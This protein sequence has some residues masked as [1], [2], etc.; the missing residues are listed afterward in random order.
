MRT[1]QLARLTMLR[2]PQRRPA[3]A[4][5]ASAS[6]LIDRDASAIKLEVGPSGQA[7]VTYKA[8]GKLRRVSPGRHRRDSPTRSQPQVAFRLNYSGGGK[9]R[10]RS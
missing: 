6:Q 5:A 2:S 9:Q 10:S 8:A 4:P 3:S 1:N 7:L